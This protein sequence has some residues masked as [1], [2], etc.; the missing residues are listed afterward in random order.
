MHRPCCSN[1]G[2]YRR[3][4]RSDT[5]RQRALLR[6]V[7]ISIVAY[8]VLGRRLL[9][10]AID[11]DLPDGNSRANLSRFQKEDL[12]RNLKTVSVL[13]TIAATNG[14]TPAQLAIAWILSRGED[15]V[16][17]F[18]MSRRLRLPENLAALDIVVSADEANELD[19]AFAPGTIVVLLM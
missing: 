5:G 10:G 11:A 16:V 17:L 14:C 13:D 6:T 1:R 7:G 19:C 15:I 8:N 2:H 18:G 3:N 12:A 4:C 9:T